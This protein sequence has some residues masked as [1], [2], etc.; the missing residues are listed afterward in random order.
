MRLKIFDINLRRRSWW[1]N[2][3]QQLYQHAGDDSWKLIMHTRE[4]ML[5][6]YNASVKNDSTNWS[7]VY[8][9]FET[10]EMAAL[11][12]LTFS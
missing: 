1:I 9:E 4:G 7:E 5:K 8:V 12:L 2:F 10:E 11:F 3:T 6:K